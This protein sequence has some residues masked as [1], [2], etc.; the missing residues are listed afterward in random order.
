MS[1]WRDLVRE[2]LGAVGLRSPTSLTW[3]GTPVFELPHELAGAM[4]PQV[5]YDYVCHSL[6]LQL[7]AHVYCPGYPTAAIQRTIAS[8]P[9]ARDAFVAALSAANAGRGCW[10]PGWSFVG[11]DATKLVIRRDGLSL[12]LDES[13]VDP[14]DPPAGPSPLVSIR[15]PNEL[16]R[17]SPG[18]YMALGDRA[19][20]MKPD[21][22]LVRVYWHIGSRVAPALV[23]ALT[24]RLNADRIAFRLKVVDAPDR[25]DR[26]DAGVLYVQR[27]AYGLAEPSVHA[28]Y[29]ELREHMHAATPAFT[30]RL[31]PG[32]GLAEDPGTGE[33]FGMHRSM[34]LAQAVL[35]AHEVTAQGPEAQLRVAAG[36]FA[37]AAVDLDRPHL[38]PNSPDVYHPL[39][40]NA[41]NRA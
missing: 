38:A 31:A 21:D 6:Q 37:S 39:E 20:L 34:I 40:E 4:S 15:L 26:C 29:L 3:F 30:M 13:D 16:R 41:V 19:V 9:A 33:S 5:A 23:G 12:W 25:Y 8:R 35:A 1:D 32:L 11:R 2:V 17:L 36:V 24:Q 27:H 28:T 18:F 10:E 14:P 22:P 7:Y